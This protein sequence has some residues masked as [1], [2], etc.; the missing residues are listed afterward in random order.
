VTPNTPIREPDQIRQECAREL[1]A[2]QVRDDFRAILGCLLGEEWMFPNAYP[3][4][5]WQISVRPQE[6]VAMSRQCHQDGDDG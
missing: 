4:T 3:K 2:V 5:L 1:W 6:F